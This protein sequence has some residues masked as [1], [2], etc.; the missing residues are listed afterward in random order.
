MKYLVIFV[1][2]TIYFLYYRYIQKIKSNNT[3]MKNRMKTRDTNCGL[4]RTAI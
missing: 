2:S 3:V 4:Y 1:S